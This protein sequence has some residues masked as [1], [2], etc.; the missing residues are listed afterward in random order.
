MLLTQTN[1]RVI[2]YGRTISQINDNVAIFAGCNV[3]TRQPTSGNLGNLPILS[4]ALL[5][6]PQMLKFWTNDFRRFVSVCSE[7]QL[8]HYGYEKKSTGF[9][10]SEKTKSCCRKVSKECDFWKSWYDLCQCCTAEGHWFNKTGTR[11][12]CKQ[13]G[14]CSFDNY[15]CCLLQTLLAA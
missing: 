8:K 15:C 1:Y 3:K 12:T 5:H 6:F 4:I 13:K 10:D 14:I 7:F 9:C 11:K 2:F